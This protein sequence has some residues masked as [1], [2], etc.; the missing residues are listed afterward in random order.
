MPYVTLTKKALEDSPEL[1]PL[2]P[3]LGDEKNPCIVA[4]ESE[5]LRAYLT[6]KYLEWDSGILGVGTARLNAVT[7]M[8]TA[9]DEKIIVGLLHAVD[10]WAKNQKV[11][12]LYYRLPADDALTASALERTGWNKIEVLVTY[13]HD[14]AALSYTF[15]RAIVRKCERDDIALVGQI[16]YD[17]FIYS[18]YHAD[19]L[20]G[21]AKASELKRQW[22]MND[23]RGRADVVLVAVV[24]DKPVGFVSATK[25]R[26]PQGTPHTSLGL[27]AAL[28]AYTGRWLGVH[29]IN[30]ILD[31]AK[32]VLGSRYVLLGT[33]EN[34]RTANLLYE[35]CGFHMLKKEC[36]YHK[37]YGAS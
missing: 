10:S 9:P 17:S 36:T 18:R 22:I 5:E 25:G 34:N 28:P 35:K 2:R 21:E 30:G 29:L 31:Y 1:E 6:L 27:L 32:T 12:L 26:D 11:S 16:A 3:F 8:K 7:F 33:Q 19:P 13:Q 24:D 14:L 37:H 4:R 15:D 23:C 20:I